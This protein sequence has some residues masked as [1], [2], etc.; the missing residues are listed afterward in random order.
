MPVKLTLARAIAEAGGFTDAAYQTKVLLIR[1]SIHQPVTRVAN[2]K[3]ILQGRVADIPLENRDII[4]V[5]KHPFEIVERALDSAI[6]TFMQ[7]VTAEA[8]NQAYS[9]ILGG[10]GSTDSE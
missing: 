2:V 7:T 10:G 3:D 6:I 1:G 4:F 9:P 5:S 8:M